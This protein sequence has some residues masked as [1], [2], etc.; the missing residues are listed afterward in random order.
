MNSSS[1]S[2]SSSLYLRAEE[3]FQQ[4][5]RNLSETDKSIC[6]VFHLRYADFHL[7]QTKQEAEA[8]A[9]YTKVGL[10]KIT[11]VIVH[12]HNYTPGT[13]QNYKTKWSTQFILK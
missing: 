4:G 5:L 12:K 9:H 7:Y 13:Y 10:H 3:L 2:S 1:P 8:V 11:D 6:Q